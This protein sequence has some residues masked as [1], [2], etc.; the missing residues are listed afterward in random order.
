MKPE[1][2]FFEE[3]AISAIVLTAIF[4]TILHWLS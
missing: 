1:I 2:P 3:I 4:A